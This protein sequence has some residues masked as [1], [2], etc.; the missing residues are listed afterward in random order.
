V[1]HDV[2]ISA[3]ALSCSPRSWREIEGPAYGSGRGPSSIVWGGQTA[4][5]RNTASAAGDASTA[6]RR[7]R[8]SGCRNPTLDMQAALAGA[9]RAQASLRNGTERE[10]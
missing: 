1:A 9:P 8:S 6:L 4:H 7:G 5:A 3:L 10:R 2:R